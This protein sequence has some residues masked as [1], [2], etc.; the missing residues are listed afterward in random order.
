[1]TTKNTLKL[2]VPAG[3]K[4]WPTVN[5]HGWPQLLPFTRDDNDRTI[6]TTAR[7]SSGR[8]V[9]FT[10][11]E[12]REK[13]RVNALAESKL[14][15][16]ERR[17]L[18]EIISYMLSL[19]LSLDSFYQ[20]VSKQKHLRWIAEGEWGRFLRSATLFEDVV[21][22]IMTTNCN[23]AQTKN[24]V[25]R[26]VELLGAPFPPEPTYKAFPLPEQFKEAGE[27]F[28]AEKIRVGYRAQA[29]IE[30]AERFLA[31]EFDLDH[32]SKLDSA[33]LFKKFKSLRG[34]GDYAAGMLTIL[35]GHFDYI[36][37]DSWMTAQA[38]KKYFNG[39]E[40]TRAQ[41]EELYRK[42]GPWRGLVAWFD[43]NEEYFRLK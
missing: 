32:I 4:F 26:S 25:A 10:C 18:A 8:V 28:L 9:R 13:L 39:T 24:M 21:K 42:W 7:L 2:E 23:W 40:V 22:V 33:Q 34:A 3:F 41:I 20:A 37:V 27:K 38:A 12:S 31:G 30:C 11:L 19:D 6:S 43:V 35:L 29:I 5:S 16:S 1:M 36:P 15:V 14:S 17:E